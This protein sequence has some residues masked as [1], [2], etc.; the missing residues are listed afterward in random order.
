MNE[1]ESI[2]IRWASYIDAG[3]GDSYDTAVELSRGFDR[4]CEQWLA[5]GCSES[6]CDTL[7]QA[8]A[9][10]ISAESFKPYQQ[11]KSYI[12]L[13]CTGEG[14]STSEQT[15]EEKPGPPPP[16]WRSGIYS[17]D[18]LTGGG[19]GYVCFA[20][21]PGVGKSLAG[22]A[23][24]VESAREGWRVVYVNTE[25][26]PTEVANRLQAYCGGTPGTMV[27][28]RLRIVNVLTGIST[29]DVAREA[30]D[31][32]ERDD[33]R[34]LI[35]LDSINRLVE[36]VPNA[37]YFGRLAMWVE[38][39]RRLALC[40]EGKVSVLAIAETNQQG[41]DKGQKAAFAANLVMS[42]RKTDD[43]SL[44]DISVTKSRYSRTARLGTHYRDYHRGVF[45]QAPEDQTE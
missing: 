18:K 25:L 7:R 40:S 21:D 3:Y 35:V 1:H 23:A 29:D 5:E 14:Q 2:P 22:L 43:D 36:M 16:Q 26:T 17:F 6:D 41:T 9:K 38:F 31:R 24:A 37:D 13:A 27:C 32:I 4:R 15:P 20:G 19:C 30:I 33:D 11:L 10:A 39:A 8:I 28:E 42:M 44:V 34:M 12:E 45:E